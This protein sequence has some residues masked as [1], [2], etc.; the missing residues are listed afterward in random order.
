MYAKKLMLL[1]LVAC[2]VGAWAWGPLTHAYIASCVTNSTNYDLIFGSGAP[3]LNSMIDDNEDEDE[4]LRQLTHHEFANL[5]TSAFTT[6]CITHNETWGAD[7]YSHTNGNYGPN[8][9]KKLVE[10]LQISTA[11]AHT[12]FESCIDMQIRLAHGPGWGTLLATA[13]NESDKT[14]QEQLMVD[15][16]AA[17]LADQVTGL[18]TSEAADDIRKALRSLRSNTIT[19]GNLMAKESQEEIELFAL[20]ILASYLGVSTGTARTYYE[21]A[22]NLT[23]DTFQAE[24]NF[25]CT[26]I[27][28]EMPE[29]IEGEQEGEGETLQEGEEERVPCGVT[30]TACDIAPNPVKPGEYVALSGL[31]GTYH[32]GTGTDSII[33]TIGFRDA[34]GVCKSDPPEKI[35]KGVPGINPKPWSGS[36]VVFTAPNAPGTYHVWVRNTV[37]TG[38]ETAIKD[39]KNAVPLT[40]DEEKN[41]RWDVALV[42]GAEGE[43]EGESEEGETTIEGEGETTTEGEGETTAEGEGE[44]NIEGEG[45]TPPEGEGETTIEGEGEDEG[46]VESAGCCNATSTKNR[47]GDWFLLG[48][49]LAAFTTAGSLMKR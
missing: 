13:A 27:K 6:G 46:E 30:I 47:L 17:E 49:A 11:Q 42:V 16:Y 5:A 8:T 48:L 22:M 36:T 25:V 38:E 43:P 15:A 31:A 33:L 14:K 1:F 21:Y 9:M 20:P 37:T 3:D 24:L 45:E 32:G 35:L 10:E 44:A 7:Y 2:P 12:L 40:A 23:E 26:M 4:A 41:D 29:A 19:T 28:Q 39:F 18:S 34:S